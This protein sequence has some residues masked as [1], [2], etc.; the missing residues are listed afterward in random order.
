MAP[1]NCPGPGSR[2]RWR[3]RTPIAGAAMID[4]QGQKPAPSPFWTFSLRLY[5]TAG[6]PPA[7]IALQDAGGVDVNLLL[8]L[9]FCARAGRRLGAADVGKIVST[10][11]PWRNEVVVPLRT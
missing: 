5:G 10:V 4:Q 2:A 8:F 9:L 11:D 7:C 3:S 1:E 6:V